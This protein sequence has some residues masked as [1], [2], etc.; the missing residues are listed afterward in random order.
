MEFPGPWGKSVSRNITQSKD[1]GLGAW[2]N[3]EIKRAITTG[4]AK[5]GKPSQA[6]DGLRLLRHMKSSDIDDIIAW[7]RTVKAKDVAA[8]FLP[9]PRAGSPDMS[10]FGHGKCRNWVNSEFGCGREGAGRLHLVPSAAYI[11]WRLS[12]RP[13]P[14]VGRRV[15]RQPSREAAYAS[16]LTP[17]CRLRRHPDA[18]R[19]L[20]PAG[21]RARSAQ[22]RQVPT[23][24]AVAALLR[25]G[26]EAGGAGGGQRLC[27]QGG[28]EP[29]SAVRRPDLPPLLRRARRRRP[30]RC[31]ARSAPA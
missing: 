10:D 13:E 27:R 17:H 3:A 31:S 16:D 20:G 5:D 21:R 26:G 12:I 15:R 14:A 25:A 23:Q 24:A 19:P 11:W 4:I 8:L 28:A 6:A 7:L 9:L 22:Q 1:K 29:Q 30:A 2:S 18:R